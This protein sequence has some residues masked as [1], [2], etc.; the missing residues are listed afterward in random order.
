MRKEEQRRQEGTPHDNTRN[1]ES[2]KTQILDIEVTETQCKAGNATR[3]R[4]SYC[5]YITVKDSVGPGEV[6]QA[7]NPNT[8]DAEARESETWA[9]EMAQW[10]KGPAA[11]SDGCGNPYGRREE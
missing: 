7:C 3:D 4:G 9:F 1:S 11:K 10:G 6:G 2:Y 5:N 8:C